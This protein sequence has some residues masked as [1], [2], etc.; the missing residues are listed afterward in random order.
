MDPR[1]KRLGQLLVNHSVA[2]K[3]GE[4]VMIAMGELD[5]F[6]LAAGVHEAVIR[7]DGYPQVQFLSETLRHQ[8]VRYGSPEQLSWVPEIEAA[9]MEWA[10]VYIGLRGAYNV[11]EHEGIPT[12]R[13]T[14]NQA[15]MGKISTLRWQKTRW[16]LLRVPN[17]AL[18]HQA[19][20]DEETIT[21]MFFNA[22]LLDWPGQS[23]KWSEW[24]QKLNGSSS[25]RLM[26]RETD[27][28]FSV[29]GRTW[30]AADGKSNMPDGEIMTA[31]VEGSVEGTIYFEFPGVLSG[32]LMHD[33]RL[34]WK[35]GRLVEATSSSNEDF[36]RAILATDAG[37]S[38][39]GEFGM[40]TN[41]AVDRFCKDILIDEKI[42]GTAH[43]AL[44]RSYPEV[45]GKNQSATHWDIVK[46]IR[47]DGC[48]EV[49]GTPVLRN[50][51]FLL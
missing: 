3:P 35:E 33:I 40:G 42:G 38:V 48:V 4:R 31:P 5:S 6:P 44:G 7:A 8:L 17:A 21:E 10:D 49:D 18:A 22:C 12:E 24:A 51:Q 32:R 9:G 14:A 39:V 45:G 15:A 28:R 11:H 25:V 27:L 34:R 13:L 16:V 23:A 1:W 20:T 19:E 43:I 46:D 50:G 36:L 26:G 29:A 30:L 47:R 37:A 2:A 41:M